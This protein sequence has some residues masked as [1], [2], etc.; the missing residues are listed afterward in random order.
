MAIDWLLLDY[1][2]RKRKSEYR[3]MREFLFTTFSLLLMPWMET[4]EGENLGEKR[5]AVGVNGHFWPDPLT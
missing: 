1:L 3:V 2:N 4:T 5:I